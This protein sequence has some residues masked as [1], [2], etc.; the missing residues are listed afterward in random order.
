[1]MKKGAGL[2]IIFAVEFP[3]YRINEKLSKYPK[4]APYMQDNGTPDYFNFEKK[5][6]FFK[7][8]L[9][10]NGFKV[11]FCQ[12]LELSHT[13]P[14]TEFYIGKFLIS[15]KCSYNLLLKHIFVKNFRNHEI[16]NVIQNT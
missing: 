13:Y 2:K 10:E 8:L 11:N 6:E 12:V 4:Y 3:L 14:S 1:M 7:K 9:V 15:I 16:Y 5:E